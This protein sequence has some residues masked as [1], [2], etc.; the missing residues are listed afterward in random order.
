MHFPHISAQVSSSQAGPRLNRWV[1]GLLE[2]IHKNTKV[3]ICRR[4]GHIQTY[5]IMRPDDEKENPTPHFSQGGMK[6]TPATSFHSCIVDQQ[7]H[8]MGMH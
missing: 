1:L 8:N 7:V 3:T 5:M 2:K 4:E 6:G